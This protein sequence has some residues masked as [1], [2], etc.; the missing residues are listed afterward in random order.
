MQPTVKL[1]MGR[2]K[3]GEKTLHGSTTIA[4]RD[5]QK[6][7][8]Y[9]LYVVLVIKVGTAVVIMDEASQDSFAKGL[10]H[11]RGY[12]PG[13][14]L[15]APREREKCSGTRLEWNF[16]SAQS[17]TAGTGAVS[18][19]AVGTTEAVIGNSM[20]PVF[21]MRTSVSPKGVPSVQ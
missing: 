15:A 1:Q 11:Q 17:R 2:S 3:K 9:K 12:K 10:P 4:E 14:C 21:T 20:G 8:V 7:C 5:V 16:I 13:V 6:R 19:G 18:R